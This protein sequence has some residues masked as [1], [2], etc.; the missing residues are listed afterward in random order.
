MPKLREIRRYL[1]RNGWAMFRNTDHEYYMKV[2]PN[3]T[4]LYTKLSHGDGEIPPRIWKQMLKQ[5]GIT[6]EDFNA[7]L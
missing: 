3:G 7:G 5:M 1:R 2:L 6:Q 4:A